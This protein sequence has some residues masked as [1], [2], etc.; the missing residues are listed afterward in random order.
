MKGWALKTIPHRQI[1]RDFWEFGGAN[2]ASVLLSLAVDEI[3][4]PRSRQLV[5]PKTLVNQDQDVINNVETVSRQDTVLRLNIIL[6]MLGCYDTKVCIYIS[7]VNINDHCYHRLLG[8]PTYVS[9]RAA[10][11]FAA[12]LF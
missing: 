2:R 4:R 10:L 5:N 9:S 7:H 6:Y 1:R 3:T 12:V 8:R 11:G